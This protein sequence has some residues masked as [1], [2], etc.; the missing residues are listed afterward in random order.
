M[1]CAQREGPLFS[2]GVSIRRC[3]LQPAGA[4]GTSS[5]WDPLASRRTGQSLPSAVDTAPFLFEKHKYIIFTH[6]RLC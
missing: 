2:L 6:A 5:R 1:L 4:L 3:R